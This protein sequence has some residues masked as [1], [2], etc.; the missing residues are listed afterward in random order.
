MF[1]FMP[2]A[3]QGHMMR[4]GVLSRGIVDEIVTQ[5]AEKYSS[6]ASKVKK[7]DAGDELEKLNIP[8]GLG[9]SD[10]QIRKQMPPGWKP[11]DP[12]DLPLDALLHYM[13]RSF[14]TVHGD[15]SIFINITDVLVC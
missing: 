3:P 14:F 15:Y 11:G 7:D 1:G 2:P 9:A 6:T 10:A 4:A 5:E 13:G 8:I 12:V